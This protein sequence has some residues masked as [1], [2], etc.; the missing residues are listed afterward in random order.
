MHAFCLVVHIIVSVLLIFIVLMQSSK[1]DGLA[2]AFGSGGGQAIFGA[3]TGDVLTKATTVLAII[4]MVT[5]I[6]LAFLT[7]RKSSSVMK[8]LK[9]TQQMPL[10][11][12]ADTSPMPDQKA[13]LGDVKGKIADLTDTLAGKV[14]GVFTKSNE[15][16]DADAAKNED[17]GLVKT[18]VNSSELEQVPGSVTEQ[19]L[20]SDA[21]QEVIA[22]DTEQ[23]LANDAEQQS[24]GS[25][26]Q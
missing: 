7:A 6:S 21:E 2:G 19:V 20:E 5:S 15:A 23:A 26:V 4:F 25:A 8:N 14:Q 9:P 12:Q 13:D 16:V 17:A 10:A 1:G 11:P 22:I 24:A 3:R 18:E